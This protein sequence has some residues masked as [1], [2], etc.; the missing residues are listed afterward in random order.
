M[1]IFDNNIKLLQKYDPS[2]ANRV[3][4]I[5]FPENV[6]ITFSKDGAPV[7]QITGISLHSLYNP[8]KEGQKITCDFQFKDDSRTVIFGLG[9]GYHIL[10]LAQRGEVTVIEPLMTLFKAFMSS[11][12]LSPFLPRVRFRIAETPASLLARY[13]PLNWNIFRHVPS[14]RIGESYYQQLEK[15]VDTRKI[16]L[17]KSLRVLV[18][19]PI[20]GGSLPTANYCLEGLKNLGHE[21]EAVDCDKFADAFFSLKDTTKIKAN[22]E[23]LSEKFIGLMGE[24]VAAKAVEYKPDLILALAQ[25]PLSAEAIHRLKELNIPIAFWFVEDF[26]TLTYWK[27]ISTSYDHFFTIQK[28]EFHSELT[29]LGVK[30]FYYLPQAAHPNVHRP[31]D[32]PLDQK[33]HYQAD[34]AF[35]GAAYHNRVQSFPRLLEYDFKI[36][37]TGWNL[38]SPLGKKIQNNNKRVTTEEIVK[39]YNTGKINLN[40]HSS[41]FHYG[42]NPEGDFVNPRTFEIAACKGFQI[43]DHRS[44]LINLF[45]LD[46]E[47]IVF[48]SLDEMKDQINYYLENPNLRQAIANRSYKRVLNEHTIEHRMHEMLLHIFINRLDTLKDIEK[49]RLDPL[50]YCISKAGEN[51]E[52]GQYLK[53]FKGANNFSLKTLANHVHNGDGDL[54]DNET[55]LIMLD[56]LIKEKV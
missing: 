25:A 27:E 52:L 12:D 23:I 2:L 41:T 20:Y 32:I 45:N 1:G 4:G 3:K 46:E 17:Q 31:L 44:D 35:L 37:G 19:K 51:T 9:F 43:L 26:R 24:V 5:N 48:H 11:V 7:P 39:I 16:L 36:W 47:L 6:K 15:G 30:D 42:I 14:V 33:K 13:E 18:V 55:L 40:L 56:Q 29:N 22:A 10:P 49:N 38:E 21:V 54:D 53:K 50:A 8:K 34:I 28:D